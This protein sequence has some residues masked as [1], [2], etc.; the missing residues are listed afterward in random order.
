[1]KLHCPASEKFSGGIESTDREPAVT[2]ATSTRTMMLQGMIVMDAGAA[3]VRLLSAAGF[4]RSVTGSVCDTG[5]RQ[6][7]MTDLEEETTDELQTLDRWA[8]CRAS[9]DD[10]HRQT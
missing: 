1:M 10:G 5:R 4:A 2:G 6:V 7:G 3:R 9:S 8:K